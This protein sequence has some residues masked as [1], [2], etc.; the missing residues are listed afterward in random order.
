MTTTSSRLG[1]ELRN[2]GVC[3]AIRGFG[4]GRCVRWRHGA[5]QIQNRNRGERA[6][7]RETMGLDMDQIL[8]R[9]RVAAGNLRLINLKKSQRA[10]GELG[11]GKR[12]RYDDRERRR[13]LR[14]AARSGSAESE[15][16]SAAGVP[17]GASNGCEIYAVTAELMT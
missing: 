4:I 5:R 8:L 3:C 7:R 6:A 16:G 12:G 14:R 17:A 2:W 15:N 9:T 10:T 13:V 11:S 1:D